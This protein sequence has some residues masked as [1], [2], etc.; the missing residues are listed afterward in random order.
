MPRRDIRL[1]LEC[2][3]SRKVGTIFTAVTMV[4][5]AGD[6]ALIF[7]ERSLRFG[8]GF[9]GNCSALESWPLQSLIHSLD[10]VSSWCFSDGPLP[11]DKS[12]F[13]NWGVWMLQIG[14]R[15]REARLRWGLTLRE[16]EE[17]ST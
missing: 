12:F 5:L 1:L 10:L 3:T 15:L 4:A 17:R 2:A 6:P 11:S 8:L 9:F 13:G 14:A 16:V 7:F